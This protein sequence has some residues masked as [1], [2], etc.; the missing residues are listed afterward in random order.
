MNKQLS[1]DALQEDNKSRLLAPRARRRLY[2][3]TDVSSM[4]CS[5]VTKDE[6]VFDMTM[7]EASE[8]KTV[9]VPSISMDRPMQVVQ[10]ESGE[11]SGTCF[12][13]EVNVDCAALSLGTEDGG[14]YTFTLGPREEDWYIN[15]HKQW[16]GIPQAINVLLIVQVRFCE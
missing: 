8:L 16:M 6:D 1:Q 11:H 7:K 14:A 13:V 15:K 5:Q 2:K 4:I 12:E 3:H 9:L 10:D